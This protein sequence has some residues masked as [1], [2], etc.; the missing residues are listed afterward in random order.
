MNSFPINVP[1]YQGND[2]YPAYNEAL[3]IPVDV[4]K[5]TR[6]GKVRLTFQTSVF[7]YETEVPYE[8]EGWS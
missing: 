7:S 3:S 6:S 4:S 5:L 1:S 2:N 8:L